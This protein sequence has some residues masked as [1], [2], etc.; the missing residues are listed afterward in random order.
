M[1]KM[2]KYLLFIM[3]ALVTM[4]V[5]AQEFVRSRPAGRNPNAIGALA[6]GL[7]AEGRATV[8]DLV[9]FRDPRWTVLTIAQIAASTADAE[10]SLQTFHRCP[11]CVETG[12]S[13]FVV[14]RR[15]DTHKYIIAGIV[16]MELKRLPRT[17]FEIAGPYGNGIGDT[18][19]HCLKVS[20]FMDTRAPI[21]T[22]S[23]SI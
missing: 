20:L 22:T 5:S 9:T 23:A 14:G 13:R 17:T 21:F 3:T 19:G 8:H 2:K 11:T 15:P 10:T 6:G 12:I 1:G 4:N 16:E 7:A 18:F